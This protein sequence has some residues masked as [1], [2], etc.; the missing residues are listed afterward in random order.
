M[1]RPLTASFPYRNNRTTYKIPTLYGYTCII[2]ASI[3]SCPPVITDHQQQQQPSKSGHRIIKTQHPPTFVVG[4]RS[5]LR[6]H[7]RQD[8]R[9]IKCTGQSV[10]FAFICAN[11]HIATATTRR[12]AYVFIRGCSVVVAWLH[13][14]PPPRVHF[15]ASHQLVFFRSAQARRK[16]C[17]RSQYARVMLCA[18]CVACVGSCVLSLRQGMTEC[19]TY[20]IV[21]LPF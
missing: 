5:F 6:T 10:V 14:P 8:T 3:I 2:L 19:C 21:V 1:A 15:R 7:V 12:S 4:R 18:V 16:K 11:T 17:A 20:V 9:P 13:P